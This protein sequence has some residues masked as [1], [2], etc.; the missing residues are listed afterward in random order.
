MFSAALKAMSAL[1]LADFRKC[2]G[3]FKTLKTTPLIF[4]TVRALPTSF[5]GYEYWQ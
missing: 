3:I 2:A 1:G 5:Y 4:Y